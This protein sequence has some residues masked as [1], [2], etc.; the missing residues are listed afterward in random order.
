MSCVVDGERDGD[1]EEATDVWLALVAGRLACED[2]EAPHAVIA[3]LVNAI[4]KQPSFLT[5]GSVRSLAQV[6]REHAGFHPDE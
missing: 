1:G 2:V 4:A 3:T 6:K 5:Y